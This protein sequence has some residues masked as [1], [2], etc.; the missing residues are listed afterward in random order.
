MT[1]GKIRSPP[2]SPS[3]VPK[4]AVAGDGATGAVFVVH[5]SAVE[6]RAVRL[7]AVNGDAIAISS[8]LSAGERV[9]IGDLARLKDGTVIEIEP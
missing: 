8:G 9:A 3:E 1:D 5:D 2:G 6:R 4:A 7:G